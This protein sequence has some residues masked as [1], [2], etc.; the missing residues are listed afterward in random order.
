MF[1]S[2][3]FLLFHRSILDFDINHE[4]KHVCRIISLG[5]DAIPCCTVSLKNVR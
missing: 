5:S 3:S 4:E 1:T 2:L